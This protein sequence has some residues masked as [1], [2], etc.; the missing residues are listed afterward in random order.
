M[1]GPENT[2]LIQGREIRLRKDGTKARAAQ[3]PLAMKRI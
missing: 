2:S 3:Q 1:S